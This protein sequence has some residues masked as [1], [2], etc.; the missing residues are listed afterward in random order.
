[1]KCR[2]SWEKVTTDLTIKGSVKSIIETLRLTLSSKW[3][4]CDSQLHILMKWMRQ[5]WVRL[6]KS[7]RTFDFLNTDIS[8]CSFHHN[9][10]CR[11]VV[12]CVC[13][14]W[15]GGVSC[16]VSV[17]CDGV[18]CHVLYLRHGIPVWAAHWSKYHCYKQALSRYDLRQT[19]KPLTLHI[20]T[21]MSHKESLSN[22]MMRPLHSLL[23]VN[24]NSS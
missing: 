23:Y 21:P 22:L 9:S 18:R 16:P 4:T 13:I 14:L 8:F 20:S 15:R 12:S 24:W 6:T 3:W 1:M 5:Y 7:Y 11:G 17:Y 10:N 19:N 2:H